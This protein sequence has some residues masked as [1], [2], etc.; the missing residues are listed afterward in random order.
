MFFIYILLFD[1]VSGQVH[2]L[3]TSN[4]NGKTPFEMFLKLFKNLGPHRGTVPKPVLSPIGSSLFPLS[5]PPNLILFIYSNIYK[6]CV[7]LCLNHCSLVFSWT[8]VTT[9]GLLYFIVYWWTGALQWYLLIGRNELEILSF[10]VLVMSWNSLESYFTAN[11]LK[12]PQLGTLQ[13]S[14]YPQLALVLLSD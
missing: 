9:H 5:L 1:S 8:T 6:V 12:F 14:I 3:F 10:R 13:I 2:V 11:P 7:V 4:C